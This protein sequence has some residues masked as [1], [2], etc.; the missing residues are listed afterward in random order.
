MHKHYHDRFKETYYTKTLRNGLEVVVLPKDPS[1]TTY[2]SLSVPFGNHHLNF[3][4]TSEEVSLPVG[5]AHFF[6]HKIYASKSGDMFAKFVKYGIE[7]NAMTSYDYTSYV[8]TATSHVEE[9]IQLLF[10][11]LDESYF[12]DENIETE[13][14]IIKEEINM[15]NDRAS[16]KMYQH[17]Y[18][19]MFH[20]HPIKYD[21]L[22]TEET[23]SNITKESLN[24]MHQYM[25]QKSNRLLVIAGNVDIERLD[26]FLNTYD[27]NPVTHELT[28]VPIVEPRHV[29]SDYK[30]V[31]E[32]IEKPRLAIGYKFSESFDSVTL[33]KLS[34]ALYLVLHAYIGQS[35]SDFQMLLDEQLLYKDLNYF[36]QKE[37]F[38]ESVILFAQTKDP[39]TLHVKL[40]AIFEKPFEDVVTKEIFSRLNNVS[41]AASI[42]ML[43]DAE[44]KVYL[45]T[46]YQL[47]GHN[48]FDMIEHKLNVTYEDAKFAFNV[49]KTSYVSTLY[50]Y[51]MQKSS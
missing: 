20:H 39:K 50:M 1:Y 37:Q 27:S 34:T 8:F 38:A 46:K 29:V 2:V 49:F 44:N 32:V 24:W 21:V 5:S 9:G 19:M 12:T 11:T 43:D 47:E 28:Y 16:T 22:G 14:A 3:K 45:F 15:N 25:Y 31:F 17:L 23:I 13:R 33:E 51:P 18:E 26:K 42:E 35:S 4:T 10:D 40:K 7:P 36:V 30:E 48:L 41:L 6:E